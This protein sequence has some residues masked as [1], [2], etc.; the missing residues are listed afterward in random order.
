MNNSD[1]VVKGAKSYKMRKDGNDKTDE[2]T[3]LDGGTI[4]S[5]AEVNPGDRVTKGQLLINMWDYQFDNNIDVSTLNIVPGSGKP[6]E[7][8]VGKIDRSGVM[9]SVIEVRDPAPVNPARREGNEAK[10][11]QPL[12]FGSKND[13]STAGNW[14]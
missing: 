5:L 11:R 4:N 9:V 7:I 13:V 2:Y 8:F 1:K 6:F 10:N 12:H 14:E 3:F